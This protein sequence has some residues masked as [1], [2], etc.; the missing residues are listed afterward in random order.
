MTGVKAF[1]ITIV[2]LLAWSVEADAGFWIEIPE[3]SEVDCGN[4]RL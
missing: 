1:L 3:T 4:S 2:I